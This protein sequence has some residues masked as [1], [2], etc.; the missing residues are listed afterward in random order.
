MVDP[1]RGPQTI[2]KNGDTIKIDR[3]NRDAQ[4]ATKTRDRTKPL[5]KVM[6]ASTGG[7]AFGATI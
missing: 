1:T 7:R 6:A 2:H 5:Y 4:I 3:K